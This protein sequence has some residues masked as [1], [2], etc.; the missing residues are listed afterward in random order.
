MG[1]VHIYLTQKPGVG[2]TPVLGDELQNRG[3]NP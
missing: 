3:G 2:E 1:K